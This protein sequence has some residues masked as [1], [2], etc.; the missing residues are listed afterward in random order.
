MS[1]VAAEGNSLNGACVVAIPAARCSHSRH[2]RICH[3]NYRDHFHPQPTFG[4]QLA[5]HR[6]SAGESRLAGVVALPMTMLMRG[7]VIPGS[8][9]LHDR[10]LAAIFTVWLAIVA[11]YHLLFSFTLRQTRT[12]R[13]VLIIGEATRV[14]AVCASL[15]SR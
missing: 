13:R 14:N 4:H 7:G 1:Q 3:V 15:L 10:W 2:H 8:T 6:Q 11:L 12:T 5:L 9:A